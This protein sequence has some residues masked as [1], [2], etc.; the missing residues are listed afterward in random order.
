MKTFDSGFLYRKYSNEIYPYIE[1]F[2]GATFLG[3]R[4]EQK[5]YN[6]LPKVRDDPTPATSLQWD[7]LIILDACRLDAYK[8]VRGVE[9]VGSRV[10]V[11]SRTTEYVKKTFSGNTFKDTVLITGNPY[12]SL[13][14]FRELTGRELGD[15]FHEVFHV[16]DTDWSEQYNTVH[17]S[18][19]VEKAELAERLFPGKRKI[20]HFM[21]PHCPFLTLDFNEAYGYRRLDDRRDV[22]RNYLDNLRLAVDWFPELKQVFSGRT[23]ITSDHGELLGEYGL[24]GHRKEGSTAAV[25]RKVPV[26]VIAK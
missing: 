3:E 1:D 19:I 9:N 21:Q 24:H 16:W 8:E 22:W 14:N 25:L 7:N 10:S 23:V 20:L 18:S 26:E 4:L 11:G 12:F 2:R 13:G 6:S 15:V 17:P 5:A